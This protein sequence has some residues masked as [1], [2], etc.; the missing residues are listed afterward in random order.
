LPEITDDRSGVIL[1]KPI[2]PNGA[3]DLD[4]IA[5]YQRPYWPDAADSLRD[6]SR[7]APLRNHAGI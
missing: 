4:L 5:S 1:S 7:L 3:A 6:N 2:K